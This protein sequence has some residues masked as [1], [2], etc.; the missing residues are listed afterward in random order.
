MGAAA[1][2]SI[3]LKGRPMLPWILAGATS[4]FAL[5]TLALLTE[6]HRRRRALTVYVV[7]ILTE[8]SVRVAHKASLDSWL[9]SQPDGMDAL[10]LGLNA[11]SAVEHMATTIARKLHL[12][13]LGAHLGDRKKK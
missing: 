13:H 4:L 5:F 8:D 9:D 1:R 3:Y 11:Q 10:Q 2:L 12:G 6:S 7:M